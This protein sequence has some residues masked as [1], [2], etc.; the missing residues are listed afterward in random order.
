MEQLPNG[1]TY[2]RIGSGE[3][4]RVTTGAILGVDVAIYWGSTFATRIS[5]GVWLFCFKHDSLSSPNHTVVNPF[6]V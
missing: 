2:N 3:S 4:S 1:T 6:D 5:I